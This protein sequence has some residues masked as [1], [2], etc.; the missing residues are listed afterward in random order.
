MET[1]N[2]SESA[3]C[4]K[5]GTGGNPPGLVFPRPGGLVPDPGAPAASEPVQGPGQG[6]R[7]TPLDLL[8]LPRLLR[9]PFALREGRQLR[10]CLG[11]RRPA[12]ED[13]RA[14]GLVQDL[15][16]P[17]PALRLRGRSV[18]WRSDLYSLAAI[19]YEALTRKPV[20]GARENS[21]P[22]RESWMWPSRPGA[23]TPQDGRTGPRR[24][25]PIPSMQTR[26]RSV[27]GTTTDAVAQLLGHPER[28]I[29]DPHVPM[30]IPDLDEETVGAALGR[31]LEDQQQREHGSSLM[32]TPDEG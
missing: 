25:T 18:D 24:M 22:G 23:R 2:G 30:S 11:R 14:A 26:P 5:P 8:H 7:T 29:G 4:A 31:S 3:S 1:G 13:P 19:L 9:A 21:W 28:D 6:D 15:V 32:A 20:V 17:H 12:A 16:V 27:R 10:W